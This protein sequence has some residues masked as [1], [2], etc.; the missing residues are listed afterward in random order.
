M[1]EFCFDNGDKL[2]NIRIIEIK[3]LLN[4]NMVLIIRL[5]TKKSTFNDLSDK[6]L[7]KNEISAF[8]HSLSIMICQ[9]S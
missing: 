8:N 2:I 5:M 3:F 4:W 9:W 6:Y 7:S 1:I